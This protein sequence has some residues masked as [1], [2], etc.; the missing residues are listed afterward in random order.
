MIQIN[1]I[2]SRRVTEVMKQN[3]EHIY[4]IA[5]YQLSARTP[6]SNIFLLFLSD[7]KL[8][9]ELMVQENCLVGKE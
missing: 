7:L 2:H 6:P 8:F 4:V 9:Y 5:R 1:M 3:K